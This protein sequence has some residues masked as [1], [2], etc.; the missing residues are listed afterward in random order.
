MASTGFKAIS[1]VAEIL[2]MP[3]ID[4]KGR[5]FIME[6]SHENSRREYPTVKYVHWTKKSRS[7]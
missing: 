3:E 2:D 6:L 5:H 4:D 1:Q 7:L